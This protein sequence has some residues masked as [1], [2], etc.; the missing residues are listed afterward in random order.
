MGRLRK[1]HL[2]LGKQGARWISPSPKDARLAK[3]LTLPMGGKACERS[4]PPL[5][6]VARNER[7]GPSFLAPFVADHA[8]STDPYCAPLP[9]SSFLLSDPP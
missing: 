8:A 7:G 6:R 2:T 5:G 1:I 9:A 4:H 3:D